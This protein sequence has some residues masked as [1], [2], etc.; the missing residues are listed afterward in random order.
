[1]IGSIMDGMTPIVDIQLPW[2]PRELSPNARLHWAMVYR[3]KAKYRDHCWAL[4]R[5]QNPPAVPPAIPL[6]LDLTFVP[7]DRRSYDSDNL[8]ARMKSGIDG[9]ADALMIDDKRFRKSSSSVSADSV[10]GFVHVRIYPYSQ[11]GEHG[12]QTV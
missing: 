8:L 12:S 5:E 11:G 7:P 3:A 1:M 10:G 4:T 9:L 6:Q 2:P